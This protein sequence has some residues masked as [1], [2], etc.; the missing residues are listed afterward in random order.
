MDKEEN[1]SK[2]DSS[3]INAFGSALN[4]RIMKFIMFSGTNK[5]L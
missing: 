4:S 2:L 3:R 1:S 5:K